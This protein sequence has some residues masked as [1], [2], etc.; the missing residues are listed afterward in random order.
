MSHSWSVLPACRGGS[1]LIPDDRFGPSRRRP[2]KKPKAVIGYLAD[3][4]TSTRKHPHIG[5]EVIE[6]V[7][8]CF[9]RANHESAN[10]QEAR[11]ASKMA[12]K[13]MEQYQITQAD[14]MAEENS[15][16]RAK[17]GGMSTVD[18]WPATDGGRPF[19]PG[20]V[21]WLCGA[22][23]NFFDCRSYSTAHTKRIEWT[24]YGIAEHTISAAI[25]FEA[26]HN[27]VQDWSE[28]FTGIPIR[29]SYCLGLA[30][31]LLRLSEEQQN[32][33]EQ[34]IRQAEANAFAARIK[35]ER[36]DEQRRLARLRQLRQPKVESAPEL[37][38]EAAMDLDE[39]ATN[40][41]E[42]VVDEDEATGP[43]HLD[44]PGNQTSD[45]S[46]NEVSPDF[47]ENDH[48]IPPA[49][50]TQAD[51]DTELRKFL[52]SDP[53]HLP[54]P[55]DED[56]STTQSREATPPPLSDRNINEEDTLP[57]ETAE[58]KSMRQLTTFREMSKDIE[59]TVL[60]DKGVNLTKGRK[61]V[62]IAKDKE[63]YKEGREDSK[64]IEVRAARIEAKEGHE[65]DTMDLDD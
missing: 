51:F 25:A 34:K 2:L 60:K 36:L 4:D 46:D 39:A 44:H 57:V 7:K 40:M 41:D 10:E 43:E 12:A 65:P 17:R 32:A 27:Q 9:A 54:D 1:H 58:W 59:D 24:F 14:V 47:N 31:G 13:I 6:R 56:S 50:D 16:Q 5:K 23:Q 28:R 11:A 29:N 55:H 42:D 38:D 45:L 62:H 21:D 53:P 52:V 61:R 19:T 64:K 35:Q 3:L 22:M 8:K 30:D 15:E 48:E 26:V 63:A 20:W 18:I 37:E 33:T 49:V